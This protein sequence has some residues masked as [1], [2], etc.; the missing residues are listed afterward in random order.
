M[1][2]LLWVGVALCLALGGVGLFFTFSEDIPETY[3]EPVLTNQQTHV[4]AEEPQAVIPESKKSTVTYTRLST[5]VD[6][7]KRNLGVLIRYEAFPVCDSVST[8][9]VFSVETGDGQTYPADCN[10]V[11]EHTYKTRG[12]YTARYLRNGTSVASVA[13]DVTKALDAP[14]QVPSVEPKEN[15]PGSLIYADFWN[16]AS[17][18]TT[19]EKYVWGASGDDDYY[20]GGEGIDTLQYFGTRAEHEIVRSP[21]SPAGAN[22][23]LLIRRIRDNSMDIVLNIEIFVFADQVVKAEDLFK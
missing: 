4:T 12:T 22:S 5:Y 23:F 6:S 7:V 3:Q 1:K 15:P 20:D 19:L 13:V 16:A 17:K 10:G 18:G 9:E 14:P 21:L 8:K 11:V 2:I